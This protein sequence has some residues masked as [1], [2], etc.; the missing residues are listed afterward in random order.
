MSMHI[1]VLLKLAGEHVQFGH[2]Y[3]HHEQAWFTPAKAHTNP[4]AYSRDAAQ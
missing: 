3:T 1:G 2:V 4:G